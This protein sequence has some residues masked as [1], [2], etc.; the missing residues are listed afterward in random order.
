MRLAMGPPATATA[1]P[2]EAD[3]PLRSQRRPTVEGGIANPVGPRP[4][5]EARKLSTYLDLDDPSDATRLRELAA[6]ADVFAQGYRAGAL[7]RRGFG[8]EQLA[9]LRPG[10]IYVSINCYGH[11]GPFVQRPGWEQLAQSVAGIAAQQGS[12]DKR[13]LGA[14]FFALDYVR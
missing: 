2:G 4:A 11:E 14:H 1:L 9:E 12:D 7:A 3:P 13:R 10:L 5:R 6:E 8:P